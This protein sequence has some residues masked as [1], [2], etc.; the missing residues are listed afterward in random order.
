MVGLGAPRL[1]HVFEQSC[2]RGQN[3][4]PRLRS[5]DL[6][7]RRGQGVVAHLPGRLP[8]NVDMWIN[9]ALA[10]AMRVC[11]R[12]AIDSITVPKYV[13]GAV[14]HG[15]C[16]H[17]LRRRPLCNRLF[18]H[19]EMHMPSLIALEDGPAG[20]GVPGSQTGARHVFV[21][22]RSTRRAAISTRHTWLMTVSALSRKYNI[23]NCYGVVSRHRVL[24]SFLTF[25][26][27]LPQKRVAAE[28]CRT[29]LIAFRALWSAS[30]AATS[31]LPL[32]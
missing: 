11:D 26:R 12:L 27:G 24:C 30:E 14:S 4:W 31:S 10:V 32:S 23:F 17:Q 20:A 25:L 21:A 9:K 1:D 6:R 29:F 3:R 15:E 19:V 5:G 2:R 18:A 8:L 22:S 7:R 28:G 16:L 13:A